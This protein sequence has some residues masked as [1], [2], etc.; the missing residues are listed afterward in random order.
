LAEASPRFYLIDSRKPGA[1]YKVLWYHPH[2]QGSN[3]RPAA[4]KI[5]ILLPGVIS[6]PE[7]NPSRI[8]SRNEYQLP[9]APLSL[10]LLHKLQGWFIRSH[11]RE[12]Y[13]YEKHWKDIFDVARLLPI[14]TREGVK[15]TDS[16]LPKKL[17]KKA[18]KWVN[19]FIMKYPELSTASHWREMG[20][21]LNSN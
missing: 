2:G 13:Q 15:V 6:I 10:V 7:F 5:D 4:V 14:A 11:S 12:P 16:V 20:F 17:V 19:D 21:V 3:R 9:I 1:T 8:K 18:G